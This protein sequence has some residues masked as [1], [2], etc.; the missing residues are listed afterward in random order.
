MKNVI[1]LPGENLDLDRNFRHYGPGRNM[2][3]LQCIVQ[4]D[5]NL[6]FIC[7]G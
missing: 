1:N 5:F 2:T 6:A 7:N 3:H 4:I